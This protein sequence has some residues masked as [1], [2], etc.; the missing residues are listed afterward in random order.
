[1]ESVKPVEKSP[2][3]NI[4]DAIPV[5]GTANG[6]EFSPQP[7]DVRTYQI[8]GINGQTFRMHVTSEQWQRRL[9]ERQQA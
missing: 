3:Q 6:R 1:M 8:T 5:V 4:V 7:T 2:Q 9:H